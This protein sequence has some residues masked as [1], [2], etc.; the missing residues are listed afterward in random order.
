MCAETRVLQLSLHIRGPTWLK[1]VAV[2]TLDTS[3]PNKRNKKRS[4]HDHRRGGGH[5]Y[6]HKRHGEVE[7]VREHAHEHKHKKAKRSVG[8]MVA[9]T[10]DGQVVS[11]TNVYAGPGVSTGV[12]APV[13]ALEYDANE[14][15]P[16]AT[17]Y[18]SFEEV[19]TI[20]TTITLSGAMGPSTA[21]SDVVVSSLVA[22]SV[23][24]SSAVAS[25]LEAPIPAASSSTTSAPTSSGSWMRQAY[26][27]AAD[28]TSQGITFLNHFGGE[29]GVPGTS[30][31][32]PA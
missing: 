26:Y 12:P 2:Y 3:S 15:T 14:S 27:N 28:G 6:L 16:D 25:S 21:V 17:A 7:E 18:E 32:G 29:N 11:W 30:A 4:T 9:A 1:Q 19:V 23:V 5:Q 20:S 31:G 13:A 24:P 22:T 10:I 8:Q